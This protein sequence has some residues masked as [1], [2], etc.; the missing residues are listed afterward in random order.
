MEVKA[1]VSDT[2]PMDVLL[3]TDVPE[4]GELLGLDTEHFEAMAVT[5]HAQGLKA[6]R[7]GVRYTRKGFKVRKKYNW[8]SRTQHCRARVDGQF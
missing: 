4:L 3:G 1:A 5:T 6:E 7:I 2:L 8:D